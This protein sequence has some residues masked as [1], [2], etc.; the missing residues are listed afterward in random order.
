MNSGLRTACFLS[1]CF[2]NKKDK[3]KLLDLAI[4]DSCPFY[5]PVMDNN[6]NKLSIDEYN[7]M[8]DMETYFYTDK[9]IATIT[10][11]IKELKEKLEQKKRDLS[12][13]RKGRADAKN[14]IQKRQQKEQ[15]D[16]I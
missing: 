12:E 5:K 6:G 14:R 3:C 7:N 2:A 4:Y 9:R 16:R 11:E 10:D 1:D 15:V 13:A 8:A